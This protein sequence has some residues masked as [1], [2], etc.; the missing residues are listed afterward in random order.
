MVLLGWVASATLTLEATTMTDDMIPLRELLEKGS[1]ATL[2]RGM[3]GFA[4]SG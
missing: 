1:D 4:A 3:I 2:L